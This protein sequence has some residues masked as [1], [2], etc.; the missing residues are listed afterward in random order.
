MKVPLQMQPKEIYLCL[1]ESS[2]TDAAWLK[3]DD[4]SVQGWE[5]FKTLP[6]LAGHKMSMGKYVIMNEFI[7]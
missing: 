3:V 1:S 6:F 4:L 2:K 7:I 5:L